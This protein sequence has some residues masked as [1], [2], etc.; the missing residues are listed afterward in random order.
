VAISNREFFTGIII[1]NID[2][3]NWTQ[4][5][6]LSIKNLYYNNDIQQAA[7]YPANQGIIITNRGNI[8]LDTPVD[9]VLDNIVLNDCCAKSNFLH[10]VYDGD[11]WIQLN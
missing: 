1:D 6:L 4:G 3:S 5:S 9:A 2:S 7:T 8:V 11:K 10:L